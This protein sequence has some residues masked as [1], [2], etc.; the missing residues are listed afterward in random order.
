MHPN[1]SGAKEFSRAILR[2]TTNHEQQMQKDGLGPAL[3]LMVV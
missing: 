3:R 2:Q 1:V